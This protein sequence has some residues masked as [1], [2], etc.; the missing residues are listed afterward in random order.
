MKIRHIGAV[1]HKQFLTLKHDRRSLALML[2]APVMAMLVFGFAFG[3]SPKHV[4]VIVVDNDTGA[5][6]GKIVNK[7][8]HDAIAI[9]YS[10]SEQWARQQVTGGKAVAALIFGSNFTRDASPTPGTTTRGGQTVPTVQAP[11]GAQATVFIDT[12]NQQ[13]SAVVMSSI[14][15]AAQKLATE[16]GAKNPVTFDSQ[17]AFSKAKDA[18]YID[19]FVPGIM[20]FAITL[21]TAMLTLLAFVGERTSGTLNRLKV[22]PATEGEIVLGYEAAFGVIATIQAL[23]ILACAVWVYNI[24]IVGPLWVA[25]LLVVLTAIDAQAIGILVSALAQRESQAVQ[26]I[27]FI[28]FPVFLL[29]GIFVPVQSLPNWLQPLSYLLPPTWSIDSLRNVLLRGWGI[30]H[31]WLHVAVLAGFALV[32]TILAI[33][34]LK[35]RRV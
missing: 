29:S 7:I 14:G 32:F 5:L 2:L 31:V 18:R 16:Q 34:G 1:A 17:Y 30:E 22:S 26:F 8:D 3:S 13:L 11:V 21:F 27:P 20:A 33:I 23:L 10:S 15:A 35:R 25:L 19:Y 4:P 12:T 6:A 28:I 9:S 24:L